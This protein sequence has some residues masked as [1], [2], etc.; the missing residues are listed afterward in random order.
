MYRLFA[1]L[2][3]LTQRPVTTFDEAFAALEALPAAVTPS[4][5]IVSKAAQ[6]DL[7]A[8]E[9]GERD[10]VRAIAKVREL[11]AAPGRDLDSRIRQLMQELRC[12]Y[13]V[14]LERAERDIAR[15]RVD[16]AGDSIDARARQLMAADARFA[17]TDRTEWA[18]AYSRACSE[19]VREMAAPR[20]TSYQL[21][22]GANP[23]IRSR[24]DWQRRSPSTDWDASE[25][26]HERTLSIIRATPALVE[27]VRAHEWLAAY[28][29]AWMRA[30]GELELVG[31][32]NLAQKIWD[33][34]LVYEIRMTRPT[35]RYAPAGEP[36]DAGPADGAPA[37]MALDARI[38]T[39]RAAD[40][41]LTYTDALR[42]AERE[43]ARAGDA[44]DVIVDHR[45]KRLLR[46]D[47][48]LHA[49]ARDDWATA[50]S[51]AVSLAHRQLSQSAA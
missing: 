46:T 8:G 9:L 44:S 13:P 34:D 43:L 16:A 33:D 24:I 23:L 50:Y 36:A 7:I 49:L 17:V 41:S 39:L 11:R 29:K 1:S 31:R 30:L 22:N 40:S 14:A 21:S 4:P 45:A 37:A 10:P 6:F 2:A 35:V 12:P 42:Q 48:D 32:R 20:S 3:A 27:Q 5:D 19:A 28:D 38:R 15:A 18:G 47:P 25:R 26:V 51:R